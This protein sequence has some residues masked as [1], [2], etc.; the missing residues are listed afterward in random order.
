[1]RTLSALLAVL[2]L[3]ALS[4]GCQQAYLD[5]AWS[6][7]MECGTNDFDVDAQ[8]DQSLETAAIEGSFFIEYEIDLGLFGRHHIWE[9][10]EIEDG[11]WEPSDDSVSGSIVPIAGQ[12]NNQ[13]PTWLFE[14][15]PNA[16]YDQLEGELQRVNGDG[17]VIESCDAELEPVA[18]T[19]N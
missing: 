12:A 17:D 19:G 8:F 15:A 14:L 4:L 16:D 3:L 13:A 18:E 7:S 2:A 5:G 6:G 10:G 1:M 9:K 11:E